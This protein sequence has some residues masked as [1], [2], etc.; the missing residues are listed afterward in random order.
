VAGTGSYPI[1]QISI[2]QDQLISRDAVRSGLP[3]IFKSVN[4]M[5]LL[6]IVKLFLKHFYNPGN[7]SIQQYIE[8]SSGITKA[9]GGQI[10]AVALLSLHAKF[11]DGIL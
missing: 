10:A 1:L 6:F 11:L 8:N 9:A 3:L 2:Y 7:M 4:I 5:F